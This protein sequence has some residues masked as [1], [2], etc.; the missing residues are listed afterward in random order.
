MSH[1]KIATYSAIELFDIIKNSSDMTLVEKAHLEFESRK[2]TA[3]QKAKIESDY[4]KSRDLQEKRKQ[5]PL[6]E[7]E[8]LTFFFL[9]FFTPKWMHS[10]DAFSATEMERFQKYGFETKMKQ[11]TKIKNYGIIFWL[12]VIMITVAIASFYK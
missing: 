7:E 12:L 1:K 9:P 5:E 11:A 3:I 6:T 8:W 2:L 10:E 4:L